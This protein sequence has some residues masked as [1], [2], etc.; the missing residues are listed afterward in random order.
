MPL[1]LS[2]RAGNL[3][4]LYHPPAGP[5]DC[6]GGIVYVHPFAEE[7]NCSRR[8]VAMQ[9]RAL[10][11]CGWGVLQV[12]LY[13][14][15]DS[16]G[17]F[18]DARWEI[19]LEDLAEAAGW[20]R[21][22]IRGPISLWGLRLGGL[23][24]MDFASCSRVPLDRIVLWQPTIFGESMMTQ[25]LRLRMLSGEAGT[26]K[27]PGELRATMATGETIEIAGYELTP[28]LASVIDRIQIAPLHSDVN[29]SVHWIEI[30]SESGHPIRPAIQ[31]IL[32]AWEDDG[33]PATHQTVLG[34]PF[35]SRSVFT[36]PTELIDSTRRAFG[37]AVS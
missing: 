5:S 32:K 15:G 6:M 24:A 9:S 34:Q 14:C 25:F 16:A 18:R 33:H 17:E 37:V 30:V 7:M 29:A 26:K 11:R 21:D 12:D 22:R 31:A 10:A 20:L 3:F 27:T 36:A 2:G 1:F 13:G 19:W 8:I 23:L 35:W 4:A 28:E